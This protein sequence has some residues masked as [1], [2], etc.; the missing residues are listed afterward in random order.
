M[1][2]QHTRVIVEINHDVQFSR[3]QEG[4]RKGGVQPLAPEVIAV[5]KAQLEEALLHLEELSSHK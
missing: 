2:I 5:V 1:D 3:F 4:E